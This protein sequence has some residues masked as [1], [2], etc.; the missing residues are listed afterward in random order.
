MMRGMDLLHTT[1]L[2][3]VLREH[4]RSWPNKTALVCGDQ[5]YTYAEFD[6]RASRLANVL[7]EHGVGSG[8]RILWVGQN[9]HIVLEALLAAAKLGASFCPANWRQSPDELA[10]VLTDLAPAA[11]LWQADEIGDPI[12]KAR[13]T[14]NS[15]AWWIGCDDAAVQQGD[16]AYEQ[17]VAGAD[18]SD[19][20]VVVDPASPV[21]IMYTA[22]FSGRPQAAQLS[23]LGLIFQNLNIAII[24][25]VTPEDV[26]LNCG[27]L[28]HI[29]TFMTTAATFQLAGTNVFTKRADA[30][31]ICRLTDAEKVTGAFIL[32]QVVQRIVEVNKDRR[33]DL[34]S[35]QTMS[36][37]NKEFK[38]MVS[39]RT[40]YW[41]RKPG[42]YGQTEVN[43]LLT[44]S[45]FG[46][47]PMAPGRPTPAM[48]VRVVDEDGTELP[49]GEVGEIVA[50]GPAAMVGYFGK[51]EENARRQRGGWHH[52][53]DLGR[54]EPDGT[55]SFVGPKTELIKTGV[56]NVYPAEVEGALQKH[57]AVA[58]AVVIG[59]PDPVWDQNVKAVVRLHE[60]GAATAEDL[61]EHCKTLIASY[62]KPKD[63]DFVDAFPRLESGF[64]DR[65]AVKA[66]HGGGGTGPRRCPSINRRGAPGSV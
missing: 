37:G 3:D 36:M 57:P 26:Y 52:T 7:R 56:E 48:Q 38:E 31:E 47:G 42:G 5:R 25:Q 58:E 43:G 64:I 41:M 34:S 29:A 21:L 54:R 30:E 13:E 24:Q 40:T 60:A 55:I 66:A 2:G 35:L 18:A 9:C 12:V 51:D 32:P 23:H 46:D 53:N 65:D 20:D 16:P 59:V 27:P 22:A 62:K 10:Y 1:T 19:P 28:F 6:A 11:V 15:T 33:Y 4:G 61:I 14:T 45:A 50:R 49:A 63:V 8:D 39:P 17:I 44:F